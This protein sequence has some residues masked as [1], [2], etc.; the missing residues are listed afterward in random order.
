MLSMVLPWWAT[1]FSLFLCFPLSHKEFEQEYSECLL[2]NVHGITLMPA[3]QKEQLHGW[4][5]LSSHQ[6]LNSW[7]CKQ[8]QG[9]LKTQRSPATPGSPQQPQWCFSHTC[10]TQGTIS[11]L[12]LSSRHWTS[13]SLRHFPICLSENPICLALLSVSSGIVLLGLNKKNTSAWGFTGITRRYMSAFVSTLHKV[14]VH[15]LYRIMHVKARKGRRLNIKHL[16]CPC[17]PTQTALW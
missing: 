14:S 10:F 8:N 5:V 16:F 11:F 2:R 12:S 1:I 3:V 4:T 7:G 17:C 6:H 9:F 15:L 13:V